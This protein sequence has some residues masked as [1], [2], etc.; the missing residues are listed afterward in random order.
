MQ[1][2]RGVTGLLQPH[3]WA[4]SPALAVAVSH[5]TAAN[6]LLFADFRAALPETAEASAGGSRAGV[7]A[8]QLFHCVDAGA[9]LKPCERRSKPAAWLT[10]A[11][12]L[13]EI[14]G[15]SSASAE[16]WRQGLQAAGVGSNT[17]AG[18]QSGVSLARWEGLLTALRAAGA[19]GRPPVAA[20]Q[21]LMLRTTQ[22]D[23]TER[24]TRRQLLKY[25]RAVHRHTPVLTDDIAER[26][27]DPGWRNAWLDAPSVRSTEGDAHASQERLLRASGDGTQQT[28][29]DWECCLSH[30]LDTELPTGPPLHFEAPRR[31]RGTEPPVVDCVEHAVRSICDSIAWDPHTATFDPQ[32]FPCTTQ[33]AVFEFYRRQAAEAA[34]DRAAPVLGLEPL[35]E[36]WFTICGDQLPETGVEYFRRSESGE[37]ALDHELAPCAM[38]LLRVTKALLG[39]DLPPSAGWGDPAVSEAF[40]RLGLGHVKHVKSTVD[41]PTT[42]IMGGTPHVVRG[43]A[44]TTTLGLES[45]G[46]GITVVI[47]PGEVVGHCWTRRPRVKIGAVAEELLPEWRAEAATAWGTAWRSRELAEC[48]LRSALALRFAGDDLLLQPSPELLTAAQLEEVVICAPL[49]DTS[50]RIQAL[51]VRWLGRFLSWPLFLLCTRD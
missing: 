9:P 12:M 51:T 23:R 25:L 15:L 32:R 10:D 20:L 44:C 17:V 21:F 41:E 3:Q 45:A 1:S 50:H 19:H 42:V 7:L 48:P 43:E 39:L 22:Q 18:A 26:F 24:Q 27:D 6:R 11:T 33:P 47:K 29:A 8:Q 28:L 35:G 16:G 37:G 40:Q 2:F 4:H 14:V 38:N 31:F 49:P 13:G 34:T 30:T 36:R 46:R 5:R